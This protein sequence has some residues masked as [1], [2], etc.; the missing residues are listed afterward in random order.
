MKKIGSNMQML[1]DHLSDKPLDVSSIAKFM[2]CGQ[3]YALDTVERLCERG[4]ARRF[5]SN[6]FVKD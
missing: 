2:Q 6:K 3:Q 1:A 4:I 5:G